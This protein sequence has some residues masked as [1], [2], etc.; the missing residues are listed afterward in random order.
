MFDENGFNMIST[1]KVH[2]HGPYKTT[3]TCFY[4]QP[5]LRCCAGTQ[6][7]PNAGLQ[8]KESI[9]SGQDAM[10]CFS[11]YLYFWTIL[12]LPYFLTSCT[13][14]A[15]STKISMNAQFLDIA[16]TAFELSQL[17]T[18]C[19]YTSVVDLVW[20]SVLFCRIFGWPI[21]TVI[22]PDL[23]G[24]FF[25]SNTC[26][27]I[28]WMLLI[29]NAMHFSY[30]ITDAAPSWW[31]DRPDF[32]PTLY[33]TNFLTPKVLSYWDFHPYWYSSWWSSSQQSNLCL[34]MIW[35]YT[36]ISVVMMI[37]FEFHMLCYI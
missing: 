4:V 36:A 25:C 16:C 32:D 9:L 26:E 22:S 19:W 23:S 34:L 17:P 15:G 28:L 31:D 5:L 14:S 24:Y 1:S 37:D 20:D 21:K 10:L 2:K 8:K 6:V 7:F 12:L 30:Q 33:E 11:F 29:L 13:R 27:S 18:W 3:W 35:F